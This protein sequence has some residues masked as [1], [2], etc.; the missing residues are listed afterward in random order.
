MFHILQRILAICDVDLEYG[1]STVHLA[2]NCLY[3]CAVITYV[4]IYMAQVNCLLKLYSF[5][6]VSRSGCQIH[7]MSA[8]AAN[9]RQDPADRRVSNPSTYN[10]RLLYH[11]L[12]LFVT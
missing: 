5:V 10:K 9:I 11:L 12:L 1:S 4:I 8:W 2:M 6:V 3:H 7:C